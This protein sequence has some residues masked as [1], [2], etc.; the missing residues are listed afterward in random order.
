M[1]EIT[2]WWVYAVRNPG[3]ARDL[4]GLKGVAGGAVS[5]VE[6][7]GLAAVVSEVDLADF[8]EE[9]LRRNLEDLTWLENVARAHHAVIAAAGAHSSLVPMRLATV[10]RQRAGVTALLAAHKAEFAASIDLVTGRT[11]WGVKAFPAE[12]AA[13][14]SKDVAGES[15]PAPTSG[16]AYLQRRRAQLTDAEQ[17]STKS[18]DLAERVHSELSGLAQAADLH[19]PQD[20]QLSGTS[21]RMIMNATYLVDDEQSSAFRAAIEQASA[22]YPALRL[23][24]TG[25]WPPYSFATAALRSA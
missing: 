2:G 21:S 7:A 16:A 5:T 4:D 17:A 22:Q 24:L 23:E 9:P 15:Q 3:S 1:S 13:E 6:N 12:Q 11:E 20:P 19:Q 14:A 10:Y 18:A 8:G 25:P